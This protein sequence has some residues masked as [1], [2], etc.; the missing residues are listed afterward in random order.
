[1]RVRVC[2]YVRTQKYTARPGQ[3]ANNGSNNNVAVALH[4]ISTSQPGR[5]ML[6]RRQCGM[7]ECHIKIHTNT[8]T[9]I[10]AQPYS[11]SERAS[12]VAQLKIKYGS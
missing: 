8:Y 7:R 9:Y 10:H 11:E 5:A 1:M 2:L 12:T 4:T 3:S 6:T